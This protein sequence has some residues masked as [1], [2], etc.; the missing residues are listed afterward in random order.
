[1]T[2]DGPAN[3]HRTARRGAPVVPVTSGT[4]S[5]EGL[6]AILIATPVLRCDGP[7]AKLGGCSHPPPRPARETAR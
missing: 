2:G 6:P 5:R 3:A 7:A 1:M 4:Q